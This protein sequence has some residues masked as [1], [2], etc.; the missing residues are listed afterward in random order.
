LDIIQIQR[1]LI[2]QLQQA[3]VLKLLK[4]P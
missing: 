3:I 1:Q 4:L 2:S